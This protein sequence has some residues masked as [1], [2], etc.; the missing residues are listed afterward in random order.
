MK[1]NK[2]AAMLSKIERIF[3][4]A[5]LRIVRFC[6]VKGSNLGRKIDKLSDK[7][8]ANYLELKTTLDFVAETGILRKEVGKLQEFPKRTE[9]SVHVLVGLQKKILAVN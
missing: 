3:M 9:A 4:Q 8:E 6:L 2:A 5:R 1:R 7:L